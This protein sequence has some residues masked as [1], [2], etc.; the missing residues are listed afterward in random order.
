MSVH[1][2]FDNSREL[3][4]DTSQLAEE[5]G[6][7]RRSVQRALKA[8]QENEVFEVEFTKAKVKR[9][10]S[11]MSPSVTDVAEASQMSPKRHRCRR[12]VTDVADTT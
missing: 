2:P 8:I 1:L 5:I 4:I 6:I 12:S 10:A 7:S 9:K 11:Q 3:E